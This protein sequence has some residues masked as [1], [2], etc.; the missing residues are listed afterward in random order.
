[1]ALL[2]LRSESAMNVRFLIMAAQQTIF[3]ILNL[4]VKK[5]CGKFTLL[6]HEASKKGK[7]GERA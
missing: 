7:F 3:S 5:D 4:Q 1:M 6:F 2:R